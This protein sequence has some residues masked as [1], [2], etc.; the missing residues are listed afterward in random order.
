VSQ[1]RQLAQNPRTVLAISEV[2]IFQAQVV[3]SDL[4]VRMMIVWRCGPDMLCADTMDALFD[5]DRRQNCPKWMREQINDM[6]PY[7][8]A[9]VVV[10]QQPKAAKA[11]KA[12]ARKGSGGFQSV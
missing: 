4:N 7:S 1:A 11:S 3:D 5:T 12:P 10:G 8:G 6:H 2:E 9:E